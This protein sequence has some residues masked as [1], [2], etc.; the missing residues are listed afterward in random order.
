[1]S[2]LLLVQNQGFLFDFLQCC[3]IA[4]IQCS[5]YM[6]YGFVSVFQQRMRRNQLIGLQ[7]FQDLQPPR[8]SQPLQVIVIS[9]A[10]DIQ[11]FKFRSMAS[12]PDVKYV[13]L[14]IEWP[15]FNRKEPFKCIYLSNS[16]VYRMNN[17]ERL[18]L[19]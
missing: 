3:T 7:V 6:D 11:E 18:T 12:V 2:T 14:L 13:L 15:L 9:C 5:K 19:E 10:V 17:I 8:H 1:M 16:L 4:A